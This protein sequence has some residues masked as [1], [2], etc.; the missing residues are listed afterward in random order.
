LGAIVISRVVI[1][2]LALDDYEKSRNIYFLSQHFGNQATD[3][4]AADPKKM[5]QTRPRMSPPQTRK[6]RLHSM[7]A[8]SFNE[9][10][11]AGTVYFQLILGLLCHYRIVESRLPAG[12]PTVRS[13]TAIAAW[14]V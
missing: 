7:L 12:L 8:D 1:S 5:L 4:T 2:K 6:K 9:T 11:K 10:F 13:V 14:P 3:V